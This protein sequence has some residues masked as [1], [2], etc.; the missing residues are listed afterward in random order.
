MH[1]NPAECCSYRPFRFLCH[2]MKIFKH[3]LKKSDV[4]EI[5]RNQC[6]SV[7][8]CGNID[9]V[10]S[11][12]SLLEKHREMGSLIHFV[13]LDLGRVLDRVLHEVI[14]YAVRI[15]GMLEEL[16]KCFTPTWKGCVRTADGT[17]L[18]YSITVFTKAFTASIHS[19]NA[20]PLL[21]FIL[22]MNIVTR[23]LKR[24]THWTL[25]YA[26]DMMIA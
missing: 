25:F 7:A 20:L 12:R 24:Q 11:T 15:H 16:I 14:W 23:D 9:A 21:P 13:L 6:S 18:P 22:V 8:N 2:A 10:H 4:V 19:C 26:D 17:Q 1:G 5:S 3:F